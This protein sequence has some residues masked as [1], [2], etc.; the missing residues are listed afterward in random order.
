M[1]N[2]QLKQLD[3]SVLPAT[4]ETGEAIPDLSDGG[5]IGGALAIEHRHF[6]RGPQTHHHPTRLFRWHSYRER[7]R[8]DAAESLGRGAIERRWH[9]HPC[10]ERRFITGY[11]ASRQ[12]LSYGQVCAS[13]LRNRWM[14]SQMALLKEGRWHAGFERG[15]G[16]L[17]RPYR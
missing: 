13:A 10:K 4:S 16:L 5:I 11:D 8:R 12:M 3:G 15:A 6:G 9:S 17:N 7:G 2:H 1:I 14:K